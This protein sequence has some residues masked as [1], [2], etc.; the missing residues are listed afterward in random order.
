MPCDMASWILLCATPSTWRCRSLAIRQAMK[1]STLEVRGTGR[2]SFCITQA[3]DHLDAPNMAHMALFCTTPRRLCWC[4]DRAT[5]TGALYSTRERP[6]T[7]STAEER[8]R[9]RSLTAPS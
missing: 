8:R 9:W 4:R 3:L 1:Q 2:V 6:S 7:G 5:R